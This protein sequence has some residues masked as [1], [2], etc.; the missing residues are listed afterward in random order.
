MSVDLL[1]QIVQSETLKLLASRFNTFRV[2]AAISNRHVHMGE[3]HFRELFG[4]DAVLACMRPLSQP[5]QF[6]SCH[7][8]F[9]EG[10]RGIIPRVKVLGP[11]RDRTQVEISMTDS[12]RLG[13]PPS[14]RLSG[15]LSGTPGCTMRGPQGTV[16][17]DEGVIVAARH[18]HISPEEAASYG[19]KDGQ[20]V[21]VVKDGP[22]RAM[23]DGIVVR[24]GNNHCLE[25]HL[26]F[27]EVNA[28]G[29]QNGELLELTKNN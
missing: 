25:V 21:G 11:F 29:I 14:V 2:P 26:D 12:F 19:L 8:V 7:E 3:A 13:V 15:N 27:D 1:H 10:P 18:L 5:G 20:T 17:I 9:I 6:L 23:L 24:I 16:I 28:A 22:R 4:S